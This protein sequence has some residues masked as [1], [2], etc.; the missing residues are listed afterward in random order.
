MISVDRDWTRPAPTPGQLRND[1]VIAVVAAA[2]GVLSVEIWRSAYD[3]DLGWRGVEAHLWFVLAG[4]VL[5]G[6]RRY[7]LTTLALQAVIFVVIGERFESMVGIFTLQMTFFASLYSA[8]AWSRRTREL[9]VTTV[10]VVVAMFVWLAIVFSRPDTFPDQPTTGLFTP[11]AALIIYSLVI[12]AVYFGGAIAWGHASWLSARRR[13][14]VE[15]QIRR[16]RELRESERRRAVQTERVR[17]ARDLHDVVAHH[18]SGIGIHASGAARSLANSPEVAQRALVTIE[19]SSREAVNQMHQLVG[20]LRD[21]DQ[22]GPDRGPQPGLAD[23]AGLADP[24]GAPVVTHEQVGTPFEVP[25]TV[26]VSLFRV[27]QEAIANARRHSSARAIAVTTRFG[28]DP[29]HRHVEVEILDD[30]RGAA[31]PTTSGGFGLTGIRERAAMHAGEV[32]IGP[33]PR[34][35]FRVRVRVPVE[36]ES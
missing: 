18:I 9:V 35:G 33:R 31:A 25:A 15:E 24:A 4:I 14:I 27:A 32:E 7:P 22:G 23:I 20:L 8:W 19:R 3:A 12:N 34:G 17:I 28:G 36:E 26:A 13:S 10:A 11:A 6:R 2:L 1:A 21:D 16:E 30:G 5:A 29:G